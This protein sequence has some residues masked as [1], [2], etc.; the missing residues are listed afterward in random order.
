MDGTCEDSIEKGLKGTKI[1]NW[2]E[3]WIQVLDDGIHEFNA[4]NGSLIL[5]FTREIRRVSKRDNES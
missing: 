4:L 3:L 5:A 2:R 1:Y